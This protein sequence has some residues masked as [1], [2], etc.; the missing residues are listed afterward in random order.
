MAA[1]AELIRRRKQAEDAVNR[2]TSRSIQADTAQQL[3][4]TAGHLDAR[5]QNRR[6]STLRKLINAGELDPESLGPRDRA[7]VGPTWLRQF[8]SV[9]KPGEDTS[10]EFLGTIGGPVGASISNFFTGAV[11]FAKHLPGGLA[12]TG[13]ALVSDVAQHPE[14]AISPA[15][16]IGQ[17][18]AGDNPFPATT[19]T[20]VD[21]TISYYREKYSGSP[22]DIARKALVEDPF[23]T[24]LDVG[25]AASLGAGTAFR[26]GSLASKA[27][28]S[29]E[30]AAAPDT[31]LAKVGAGLSGTGDYLKG[32]GFY[33]TRGKRPDLVVGKNIPIPREYG[34]SPIVRTGQ[35]FADKFLPRIPTA[36][37]YLSSLRGKLAQHKIINTVAGRERILGS[38]MAARESRDF[39]KAA[40]QL[41][42]NEAIALSL[43]KN[44][45]SMQPVRPRGGIDRGNVSAVDAFKEYLDA[46]LSNSLPE[47]YNIQQL[48]KLGV[49]PA[50]IQ[51][52]RT[53]LDDPELVGLIENPSEGMVQASDVW[54][55]Q[56]DRNLETHPIDAEAHQQRVFAPQQALRVKPGDL[57]DYDNAAA[58]EAI[59]DPSGAFD[60][61]AAKHAEE[62]GEP[63]PIRPNYVPHELAEGTF[64]GSLTKGERS[65][66]IERISL[67]NQLVGRQHPNYLTGSDM[68]AFLSGAMRVGTA[69]MIQFIQK[70]ERFLAHDGMISKLIS[71]L[72]E[73]DAAG[74]V[75]RAKNSS[76][77]AAK[78]YSPETHI[79]LDLEGSVR[80]FKN[81]DD[82]AKTIVDMVDEVKKDAPKEVVDRADDIAQGVRDFTELSGRKA[83]QEIVSA[84][85]PDG[86]VMTREA[87]NHIKHTLEAMRPAATKGGRAYDRVMSMWRSMT[88]S[89]MPR[90]WINTL[91]GSSF[92]TFLSGAGR[93]KYLIA[94]S[95]YGGKGERAARL[96]EAAPEL[97]PGIYGAEL[98]E[99]ESLG[100]RRFS[101]SQKLFTKVE[102]LESFF[103]RMGFFH[104]LD[105]QGKAAMRQLDE[106]LDGYSHS[107]Y[108]KDEYINNI[109]DNHPEMIE[110]A[111]NEVNRFYYN[112]TS[113]G[114]L[115]RR[116]VRRA[117]PFWGWYKFITKLAYQ[118]PFQYPGRTL[119][120]DKL[121]NIAQEYEDNELGLLPFD[122][123]GAIFLNNDRTDQEYI[124]T[125]GL[126][127]LS[128]FANPAAPEGTLQGMLSSQ[129]LAPLL[130]AFIQSLGLDPFRGQPNELSPEDNLLTGRF[131]RIINPETGEEVPGGLSG[132]FST[133]RFLGS[134]LRSVPQVRSLEMMNAGGR[135]V[136]PESIP[137]L[138][139]K[140]IPV[141]EGEVY[142]DGGP[143]S[144]LLRSFLGGF[145][146]KTENLREYQN[147]LNEDVKYGEGVRKGQLKR[148]R[149]VGIR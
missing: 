73:K 140:P 55:S 128:D 82:F 111:M 100:R 139:E 70:R 32:F 57:G 25:T 88:L 58:I 93:P 7:M 138:D 66:P 106:V 99:A 126:N 44:G 146:P 19:E 97:R 133:E 23:G 114:P 109:L 31:S 21:P 124:P 103:K 76:E 135:Y 1:L 90:W 75:V 91:V 71:Q 85:K 68:Q 81:E 37:E 50:A 24:V 95:R 65:K 41:D 12:K 132:A 26:T 36:G 61:F 62:T 121:S 102:N 125:F 110:H 136:Y 64:R 118:L 34:V 147:E 56:V 9:P 10:P 116:Y 20:V 79:A 39:I 48:Q 46:S 83:V 123:K 144:F 78:G 43:L 113:L 119:V 15:A 17:A 74:E 52:L 137:F 5:A 89:F 86:I 16:V 84:A 120:L 33:G 127:P 67:A 142:E 60:R 143:T 6:T 69:P 13:A 27:G 108:M 96:M 28:R 80:F 101:P 2:L 131:G 130:G 14:G 42:D 105:K 149:E 29:L 129:Q 92:L 4:A 112:Y 18:I 47:G 107:P 63:F 53:K 104:Q 134:L 141:E 38:F 11:D 35:K 148:L 77:M 54:D 115:E 98:H 145:P 59:K 8:M 87:A 122:V 30:L 49:D 22:G 51:A 117:V 72:A 40:K 45:V 3:G 94:A